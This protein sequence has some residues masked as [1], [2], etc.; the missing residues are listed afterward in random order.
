MNSSDLML[1]SLK[2][3]EKINQQNLEGLAAL[4]TDDHTFVDSD[5]TMTKGKNT[6]RKGWA[7]FFKRY[8]DYRNVFTCVTVQNNVVVMVGYSTCSFKPLNGANMWTAKVRGKRVS[9]WRACWLN[10]RQ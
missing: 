9:E 4:M 8:P 2:F 10:R 7:E 1:V 6:M 5:G 3:N